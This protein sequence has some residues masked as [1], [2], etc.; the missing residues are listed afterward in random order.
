MSVAIPV[1]NG[2]A[3]LRE[4]IESVLAQSEPAGEVR[5]FDN[6]S[7]DPTVEVALELLP[8]HAV[9][10]RPVN[11]GAVENFNDSARSSSPS[12]RYFAWLAADDRWHPQFLARCRELLEQNPA[13]PA[14]LTGIRF[15]DVDGNPVGSQT[16][17]ALGSPDP[18]QRLRSFLRRGRWTEFYCLYDRDALLASPMMVRDY[19]SDVLLTW[20]L[21]LRSPLAVTTELLLD[22]RVYPDKSVD[23]M[24]TALDPRAPALQWRKLR[25]W[26][27]LWR[28]S[29]EPG[30]DAATR[31]LARREL[32]FALAHPTWMNH[33]AEDVLLR[34]PV[35]GRAMRRIRHRKH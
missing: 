22:Y 29:G 1:Y 19:G 23:E 28:I 25:M 31:R 12:A 34:W 24:A 30:L 4:A 35:I 8:P 18:R 11:L 10:R 14:C 6:C 16:D 32:V 5:L 3:Y 15:I 20:W 7:T 17:A 21:L 9:V 13:R 2:A 26:S 27:T 33:L